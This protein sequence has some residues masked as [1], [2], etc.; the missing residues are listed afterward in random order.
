MKPT[1]RDVIHTDGTAKL[2]RFRHQEGGKDRPVLFLVPSLINRWYVLDLRDGHSLVQACVDAGFDTYCL[3]WGE[4]NDEDRYLEWEDVLGRLGRAL[5]RVKRF[6]GSDDVGLLG[7]C[8]GG[9]LCS[10]YT[11]LYPDDVTALVNLAGPVDF[12]H[13]GVLGEMTDRRWFDAEAIA[14]AG[15]ISAQQM[16]SGFVALNPMAQITKWIALAERGHDPDFRE[17]F[18]ALDTWANDNVAF[19]GAAYQTYIEDLY[20]DNLLVEGQ[21]YVGGR[22]VELSEIACPTLTIATDRDH[23]CPEPAARG[24]HDHVGSEDKEMYTI[25]GGHVGAVVGSRGPKHCYPKVVEW[26]GE[27]V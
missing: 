23:I 14:E 16:Q 15:N 4:P 25:P 1:P 7:Y 11:A 9:T 20:Q 19:P 10:I 21:H 8:M 12:E 18:E 17:A 27:R 3:D 24:L 5:R 26:F 6:S 22:R 13:A 2:Y